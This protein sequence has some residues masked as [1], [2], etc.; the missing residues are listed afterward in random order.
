MRAQTA[1]EVCE[2]VAPKRARRKQRVQAGVCVCVVCV[3]CVQV[4]VCAPLERG[5]LKCVDLVDHQGVHAKK[6]VKV[7]RTLTLA[8]L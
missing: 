7:C 8:G 2:T 4:C 1:L 3:V 6:G 5:P